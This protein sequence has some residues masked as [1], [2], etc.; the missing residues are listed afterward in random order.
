MCCTAHPPSCLSL[1]DGTW[2][3]SFASQ[4]RYISLLTVL[5]DDLEELL[6]ILR[7]C[8]RFLLLLLLFFI[9]DLRLNVSERVILERVTYNVK[10][11]LMVR[12]GGLTLL[13]Y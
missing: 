6:E 1:I 4:V 3:L 5:C 9:A 10:N 8:A 11:Q 2:L 13:S 12:E 7:I